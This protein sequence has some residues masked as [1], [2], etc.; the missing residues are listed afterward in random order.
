MKRA[1]F[2]SVFTLSLVQMSFAQKDMN[3][4]TYNIRLGIASDG[5][6]QWNNRKNN[7]AS[8]LTYFDADI[9]GMQEAF[10]TQIQ[11]LETIPPQ[12][13]RHRRRSIAKR[14]RKS[15]RIIRSAQLAIGDRP[16]DQHLK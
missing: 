13:H 11:D 8:I 10:F 5:D 6:N 12:A 4:M 14:P 15:T 7:L 9:C 2:I 1:L 3:I 16:L